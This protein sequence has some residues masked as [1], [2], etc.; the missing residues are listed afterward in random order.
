[1]PRGPPGYGE[2]GGGEGR[3][4]VDCNTAGRLKPIFAE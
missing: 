2:L 3:A 4:V 1:M